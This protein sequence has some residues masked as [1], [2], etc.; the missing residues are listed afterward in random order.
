MAEQWKHDS[1]TP[2]NFIVHIKD[3]E[4]VIHHVKL[5]TKVS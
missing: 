2:P 5:V 4:I 1:I 3:S